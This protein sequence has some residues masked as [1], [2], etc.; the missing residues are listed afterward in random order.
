MQ[1]TQLTFS[2]FWLAL[3][4]IQ[5]IILLQGCTTGGNGQINASSSNRGTDAVELAANGT[6]R[7]PLPTRIQRTFFDRSLEGKMKVTPA[8]A[9]ERPIERDSGVGYTEQ[10]ADRGDRIG[11]AS[12]EGLGGVALCFRLTSDVTSVGLNADE[13]QAR[14]LESAAAQ[15]VRE[16]NPELCSSG[17]RS[18]SFAHAEKSEGSVT[19]HYTGQCDSGPVAVSLTLRQI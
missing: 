5:L 6:E 3:G 2:K 8:A 18:I 13:T 10:N 17:V 7:A 15:V 11:C 1:T 16:E 4:F 12:Y 14:G 9:A 19:M